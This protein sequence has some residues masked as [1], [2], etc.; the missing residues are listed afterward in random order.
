VVNAGHCL[1]IPATWL[2]SVK[3]EADPDTGRNLAVNVW[4][5]WNAKSEL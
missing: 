3:S 2:H 1:Y 5:N 4:F